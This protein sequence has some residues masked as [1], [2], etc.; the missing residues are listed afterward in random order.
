MNHLKIVIIPLFISLLISFTSFS[1]IADFDGG[2]KIGNQPD[3]NSEAGTI[4]WNSTTQNFEGYNGQNWMSIT[5][6]FA[7]I[8]YVSNELELKNVVES[9]AAHIVLVSNIELN[10]RI[11]LAQPVFI[12]SNGTQKTING[13][14][15]FLVSGDSITIQNIRFNSDGSGNAITINSGIESLCLNHL[16]FN[17]YSRAIYK[18][19]NAQVEETSNLKIMNTAVNNSKISGETGTISIDWKVQNI[20]IDNLIIDGSDGEGLEIANGCSG[21]ISNVVIKNT[22]KIGLELWN[23]TNVAYPYA[24]FEVNNVSVRD[25]DFFGISFAAARV[26][27]SNLSTYN[28]LGFGIEIVGGSD[29][30]DY[31]PVQIS[32]ILV[33]GVRLEG[34]NAIGI[35]IDRH[36]GANISN[37]HIEGLEEPQTSWG[38]QVLLSEHFSIHD[39]QFVNLDL[40][41]MVQGKNFLSQNGSIMDN[42]FLNCKP[43]INSFAPEQNVDKDNNLSW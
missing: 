15:V 2:I 43:E 39:G 32:N 13:K 29:R 9:N 11:T 18:S 14:D 27:G 26:T 40:G 33:S 35:S 41:I 6:G 12:E 23:T 30:Y 20:L 4:R 37:F 24:S 16:T 17:N 7:P 5:N 25:C 10:S 28:T 21:Q 19:G 1:Q 31:K 38:I 3:A 36:A 8:A 42:R 34:G 22:A